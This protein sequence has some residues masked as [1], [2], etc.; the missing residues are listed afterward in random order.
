MDIYKIMEDIAEENSGIIRTKDVVNA[1]VRR[2][3]L[4]RLVEE[5]M[6]DKESRR[7][8]CRFRFQSAFRKD[9]MLPV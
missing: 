6:L 2:E 5:G 4:A 3:V 1:G 7:I 8:G 9:T